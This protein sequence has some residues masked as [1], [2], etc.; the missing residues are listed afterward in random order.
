MTAHPFGATRY[1]VFV[2]RL[3]RPDLDWHALAL[4]DLERWTPLAQGLEP[5]LVVVG[6]IDSGRL[7]G[8]QV[9]WGAWLGPVS[10]AD[11][12][13]LCAEEEWPVPDGLDG[14]GP[15]VLVA[16]ET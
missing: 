4:T 14:D 1:E 9:D 3:T 11:I 8:R 16:M 13:A 7:P 2:T 5:M 10:R 6:A 15:Y 12:E